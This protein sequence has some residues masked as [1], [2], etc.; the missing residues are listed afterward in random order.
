MN[1]ISSTAAI[2]YQKWICCFFSMT[3]LLKLYFRPPEQSPRRARLDRPLPIIG[4]AMARRCNDP[5]FTD[6]IHLSAAAGRVAPPPSLPCRSG[7]L[8]EKK[9]SG[10]ASHRKVFSDQ[11]L[12]RDSPAESNTRQG[13]GR[14]ARKPPDRGLASTRQCY[15]INY[16]T[17]N[18]AGCFI[19][20]ETSL[21][22]AG[23][24]VSS[25]PRW[26]ERMAVAPCPRQ[27]V[28][29]RSDTGPGRS[30]GVAP[31][32]LAA[33]CRFCLIQINDVAG[34]GAVSITAML[35]AAKHRPTGGPPCT[36]TS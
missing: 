5:A 12:I 35:P 6:S 16:Q 14:E 2:T 25:A 28:I 13:N 21:W 29:A 3:G 19:W 10:C 23:G 17:D 9:F 32:P 1:S 8:R 4:E 33:T 22:Q 20:G 7:K 30:L 18:F 27:S 34:I 36:R 11:H 26:V 24:R 15:H 31:W